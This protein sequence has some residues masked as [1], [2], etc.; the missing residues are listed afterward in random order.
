MQTNTVGVRLRS[1]V[2]AR[3]SAEAQ[4][5]GMALAS[6]LRQRLENPVQV[7]AELAALRRAVERVGASEADAKDG[8]NARLQPGVLVEML[9]LL[10]A[11]AGPQKAGLAQKEVERRGLEVWR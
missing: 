5:H 6:F 9:L 2:W 4:G 7:E 1:D 11:L 10:R 3:Y 8:R